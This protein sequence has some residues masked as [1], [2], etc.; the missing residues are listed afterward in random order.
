MYTCKSINYTVF[1]LLIVFASGTYQQ[2]GK[3]F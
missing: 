2:F 3:L 1:D